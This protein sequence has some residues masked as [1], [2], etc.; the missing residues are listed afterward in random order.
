MHSLFRNFPELDVAKK[1]EKKI[2]LFDLKQEIEVKYV[3]DRESLSRVV[4]CS[5]VFFYLLIW[6]SRESRNHAGLQ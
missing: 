4:E 3:Y 6:Y 5:C 2:E 1:K